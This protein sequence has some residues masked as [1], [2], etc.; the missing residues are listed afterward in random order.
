MKTA[1]LATA[2]IFL[3]ALLAS[4]SREDSQHPPAFDIQ[5]LT[6]L[7]M[8]AD[9]LLPA[10]TYPGFSRD[11][12]LKMVRPGSAESRFGTEGDTYLTYW[13]VGEA[14]T[15][16]HSGKSTVS[17]V[18][19]QFYDNSYAYGFYARKR[20]NGAPIVRLGAQGYRHGDTTFFTKGP[21]Y[22]TL[23][24]SGDTASELPVVDSL[25]EFI[26]KEIDAQPMI[27]PYYMLFPY[28][29]RI[30]PSGKFYPYKYLGILGIDKVYTTTYVVKG[31]TLELFLTMD[32]DGKQFRR[33]KSYAKRLGK[34]FENPNGFEFEKGSSLAFTYP[35]RGLIIAGLV[36]GKL[37]GA[38]G[39]D[40]RVEANE[41]LIAT[42]VKGLQ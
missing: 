10:T 12:S 37:V 30:D 18:V 5:T 17:A 39:Y 38:I 11:D 28:G 42:W 32:Q 1:V 6:S 8:S 35:D 2:C 16:Y 13:F 25:G 14:S 4:C 34:V 9:S 41:A 31:D 20:P 15:D 7:P 29:S 21:Y 3:A 33:L 24:F 36:R 27:P 26:S 22:I 40:P 23:A 19:D